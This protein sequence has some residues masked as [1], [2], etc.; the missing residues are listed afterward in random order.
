M[1][2]GSTIWS[3]VTKT[4][5]LFPARRAVHFRTSY[6]LYIICTSVLKFPINGLALVRAPMIYP[7]DQ[8][9]IPTFPPSPCLH[10]CARKG[11]LLMLVPWTEGNGLSTGY[12]SDKSVLPLRHTPA[13]VEE[14]L[15]GKNVEERTKSERA[16]HCPPQPIAVAE[17]DLLCSSVE[18]LASR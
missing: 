15:E 12:P 14:A 8:T 3:G 7:R 2:R 13:R 11:G 17:I 4:T 6:V 1:A 5:G 18:E 9:T 16:S 10:F